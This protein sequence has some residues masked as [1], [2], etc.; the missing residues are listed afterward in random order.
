MV[1]IILYE[2]MLPLI[3]QTHYSHQIADL[4]SFDSS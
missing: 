2:E 3:F 4:G 1:F